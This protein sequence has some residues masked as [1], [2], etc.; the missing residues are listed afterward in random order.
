MVQHIRIVIANAFS[1]SMLGGAQGAVQF[2]RAR[3]E[4]ARVALADP[5]NSVTSA[6]GHADTAGIFSNILGRDIPANRV[7]ITLED[8]MVLLV[9]QYVGP[10]LPEGA[11]SLPEGATIE[12]WW[13]CWDG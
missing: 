10:R 11:T 13:V 12:W 7:A 4:D 2:A 5:T 6:V 9:G 8:R 1:I 3:I